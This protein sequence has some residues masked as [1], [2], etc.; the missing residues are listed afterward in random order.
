MGRPVGSGD[1]GTLLLLLLLL[2]L[3][4]LMMMTMTTTM[5]LLL[6]LTAPAGYVEAAAPHAHELRLLK[7]SRRLSRC[8]HPLHFTTINWFRIRS[9]T[10]SCRRAVEWACDWSFRQQLAGGVGSVLGRFAA[11]QRVLASAP[12]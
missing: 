11:G 10:N 1:A 9:S 8:L 12:S 5:M 4:L 7:R 3:L 2:P 6:L